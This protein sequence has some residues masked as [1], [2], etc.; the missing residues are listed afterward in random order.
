MR[1][2]TLIRSPAQGPMSLSHGIAASRMFHR[3]CV[4]VWLL[5]VG[6]MVSSLL[7]RRSI[8][9]YSHLIVWPAGSAVGVSDS[10]RAAAVYSKTDGSSDRGQRPLQ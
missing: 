2:A 5:G 8:S 1:H 6:V 4:A 3:I 7:C 10:E 9:D